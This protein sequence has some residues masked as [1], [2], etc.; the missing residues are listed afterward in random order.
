ML[1]PLAVLVPTPPFPV[2]LLPLPQLLL[3]MWLVPGVVLARLLPP[4]SPRPILLHL[5]LP[6]VPL[7]L[8]WH[9]GAIP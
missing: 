7:R 3:L 1:A 9:R 5:V 6:P 2:P 8:G 4:V